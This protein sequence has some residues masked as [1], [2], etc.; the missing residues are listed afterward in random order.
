MKAR[1]ARRIRWLLVAVLTVG[2]GWLVH[3]TA[4]WLI[5]QAAGDSAGFFRLLL[6]SYAAL[7]AGF[8]FSAALTRLAPGRRYKVAVA[9]VFVMVVV[10]AVLMLDDSGDAGPVPAVLLGISLVIGAFGQALRVRGFSET[11]AGREA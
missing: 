8:F 11:V 4:G 7:A 6:G 10:A 5:G 2:G 9:L 3:W 1:G